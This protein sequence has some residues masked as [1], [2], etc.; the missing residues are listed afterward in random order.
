MGKRSKKQQ[1]P[2]TRRWRRWTTA[3]AIIFNKKHVT[4][5][6]TVKTC[7][8]GQ[9]WDKRHFCIFCKKPQSKMTRHLIKKHNNEKEVALAMCLP[10]RSKERLQ[11]FENLLRK[12]NYFHNIEVLEKGEGQIV[13]CRQPSEHANH[14]DYLPCNICFGFFI[15]VELWK[16]QKLCRKKKNSVESEVKS[17]G[18]KLESKQLLQHYCLTK[19]YHLP[20]AHRLWT[21]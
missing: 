5:T 18:K 2:G 13:T 20:G 21:G 6:V 9:K 19:G 1:V 16:H 10:L 12:G 14:E 8:K 3:P 11:A 4:V 7:Q 15:K 17:K